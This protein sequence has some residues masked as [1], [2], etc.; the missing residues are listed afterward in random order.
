MSVSEEARQIARVLADTFRVGAAAKATPQMHRYGDETDRSTIDLLSCVNSPMKGITAYGTVR[1]SDHT[2]DNDSDLRA[3]IIGAFPTAVPA[4]ANVITT[5]AFN[6]INDNAPLFPGAIHGEALGLYELSPTLRH[7]LF[8]SPFLW[9]HRPETLT[10]PDRKVA[11]LMAVPITE[12]E[13]AY[14]AIHGSRALEEIF[15]QKD[16]DIFDVERPSVV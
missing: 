8:V 12:A 1:L 11:W 15:E 4:F 14:T 5:C 16:I 2:L 10:L 6:V 3:E 13:R 9:E 7:I